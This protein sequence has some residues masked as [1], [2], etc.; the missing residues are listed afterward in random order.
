MHY[1][2]YGEKISSVKQALSL[3][4]KKFSLG[5]ITSFLISCFNKF[6]GDLTKVI[7]DSL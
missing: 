3:W 6:L 1:G 7:K 4:E 5:I 2:Q